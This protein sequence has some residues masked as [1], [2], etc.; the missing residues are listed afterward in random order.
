MLPEFIFCDSPEIPGPGMVLSTK[1]PFVI[2]KVVKFDSDEKLRAWGREN[3]DY[4]FMKIPGYNIAIYYYDALAD[5][6]IELED[7]I[8]AMCEFYKYEKISKNAGYYKRN[9]T[10]A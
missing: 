3:G 10:T 1:S 7:T 5:G 8:K 6:T 9:K 2:G 4:Y